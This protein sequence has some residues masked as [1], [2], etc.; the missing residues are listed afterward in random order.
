M[1][2]ITIKA[3]ENQFKEISYTN[4]VAL[5]KTTLYNC[6]FKLKGEDALK[7]FQSGKTTL[8]Q[9]G[10]CNGISTLIDKELQNI[11]NDIAILPEDNLNKFVTDLDKLFV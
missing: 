7:R 1:K 6:I 4:F 10:I 3:G 5:V 9:L 2:S 8:Y 11:H